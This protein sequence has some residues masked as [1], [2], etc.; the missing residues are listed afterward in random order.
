MCVVIFWRAALQPGKQG[1]E[2]FLTEGQQ[3]VKEIV[4][5]D[6]RRNHL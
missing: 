4:G 1:H 3:E 5:Y 2:T 6:R